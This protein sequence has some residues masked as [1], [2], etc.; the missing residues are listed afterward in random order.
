MPTGKNV[1]T[2]RVCIYRIITMCNSYWNR[3]DLLVSGFE[4]LCRWEFPHLS[5]TAFDPCQL[6]I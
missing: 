4:A 1:I 6:R 5:R 3:T 2:Y